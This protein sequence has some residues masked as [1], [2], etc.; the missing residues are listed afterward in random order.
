MEWS[1]YPGC[2]ARNDR[3]TL[4]PR[5]D[6]PRPRPRPRPDP[7][8]GP[9]RAETVAP[10]AGRAPLR[11]GGEG[12]PRD[13]HSAAGAGAGATAGSL[14]RGRRALARQPRPERGDWGEGKR[15]PQFFGLLPA[16]TLGPVSLATPL[17]GGPGR[18]LAGKTWAPAQ[19]SPRPPTAIPTSWLVTEA[20][21]IPTSVCAFG[22]PGARG[23]FCPLRA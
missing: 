19:R 7:P 17:R 6:P 21:P 1:W 12:A 4:A 11:N 9:V 2:L 20:Q 15:C 13:R 16:T 3:N 18:G 22:S 10:Q 8:P 14:P 23:Q 5:A